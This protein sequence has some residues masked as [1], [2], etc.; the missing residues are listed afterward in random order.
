MTARTKLE[1]FRASVGES[2]EL[3]LLAKARGM[4]KSDLLRLLIREAA[5]LETGSARRAREFGGRP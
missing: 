4:T 1:V 3:S 2:R 5:D